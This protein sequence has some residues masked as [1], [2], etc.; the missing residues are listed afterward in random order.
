[1]RSCLWYWILAKW[2]QLTHYDLKGDLQMQERAAKQDLEDA[3][4]EWRRG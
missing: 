1:M 4:Y 2:A 3:W